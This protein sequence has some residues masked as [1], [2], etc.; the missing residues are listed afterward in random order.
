VGYICIH[1]NRDD[2]CTKVIIWDQKLQLYY[3]AIAVIIITEICRNYV[4][5]LSFFGMAKKIIGNIPKFTKSVRPI[6]LP[7]VWD[8]YANRAVT[9]TGWGDG[10]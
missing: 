5:F 6:C 4:K 9:T 3:V 7:S 1:F 2:I 10:R 8:S